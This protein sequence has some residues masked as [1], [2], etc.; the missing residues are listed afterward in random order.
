MS[1]EQCV[2]CV[3]GLFAGKDFNGRDVHICI[4]TLGLEDFE[5]YFDFCGYIEGDKCDRKNHYKER[6]GSLEQ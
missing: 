1:D 5:N 3:H 6:T 4:A 2:N